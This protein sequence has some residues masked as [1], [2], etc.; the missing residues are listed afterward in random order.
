M[1]T[2]KRLKL[3]I[4][5][6]L[7]A[8]IGVMV[9]LSGCHM[10]SYELIL[11]R[12]PICVKTGI[13]KYRCSVCGELKTEIIPATGKHEMIY[14]E[15]SPTCFE[16][17]YNTYECAL[18]KTIVTATP[19]HYRHNYENGVCTECGGYEYGTD[20]LK[21]FIGDTAA[22][23]IAYSGEEKE[24]IIPASINGV[25]VTMIL[26]GAFS[27]N[28]NITKVTIPQTVTYIGREAFA[29][30]SALSSVSGCERVVEIGDGAFK[31]C[32]SLK[33]FPF[34]ENLAAVE[35]EAFENSAL[36]SIRFTSRNITINSYAF[37]SCENLVSVD[38]EKASLTIEA[39]AFADCKKLSRILLGAK[40]RKIG[41]GAFI[42]C[43]SLSS[44]E[45][46]EEAAYIGDYAFAYCMSLKKVKLG[47]RLN[48][49]GLGAF[50]GCSSL[51]GAEMEEYDVTLAYYEGS[52]IILYASESRPAGKWIYKA[53]NG[54]ETVISDISDSGENASDLKEKSSDG[55][56]IIPREEEETV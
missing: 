11:Y 53:T 25:N 4:A 54:K 39:G 8:S 33:S 40:S 6:A 1:R 42:H 32:V 3:K 27:D 7:M 24:V 5:A 38:A 50:E 36:T 55:F 44:V 28:E 12:E 56:W 52:S 41:D 10:H 51:E 20:G 37:K 48:Y 9:S 49:I 35:Y 19:I 21:Y 14:N 23:L 43:L 22:S 16:N 15:Y 26:D 13:K 2:M 45:G 34:G 47:K 30:C 31:N 18:C 46:L 29:S 17:G